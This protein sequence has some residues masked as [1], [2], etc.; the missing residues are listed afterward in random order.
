VSREVAPDIDLTG[1][2]A[3]PGISRL[4]AILIAQPDGTW[5]I[6]D[7]G[8]ANGTSVNGVEIETGEQVPLRN[9]DT[10]GLGAWTSI[11]IVG[12]LSDEE[13]RSS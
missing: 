7:P 10:I 3:D 13:E 6:V 5:A 9:H 1:P 4:H 2:P 11:A 8:S 12:Q